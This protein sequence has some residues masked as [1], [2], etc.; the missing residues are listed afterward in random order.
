M[1]GKKKVKKGKGKKG[2][3][4][5][6]KEYLPN[7]YNIPEVPEVPRLAVPKV[8]IFLKLAN[9]LSYP[10][11]TTITMPVTTKMMTIHDKIVDMHGGAANN[12]LMSL[13]KFRPENPV[14]LTSSLLDLGI[15]QEGDLNIYYD[16]R[17]V[18]HPLL[19]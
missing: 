14:P 1:A 17:P 5:K 6:A 9:P 12:I 7:L 15:S 18:S 4:G 11:E 10:M 16:F 2:K 3:K 19:S 13:Y 8:K